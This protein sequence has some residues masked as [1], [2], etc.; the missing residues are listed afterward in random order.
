MVNGH[1]YLSLFFPTILSTL[2]CDFEIVVF[3]V[4][5]RGMRTMRTIVGIKPEPYI[6]LRSPSCFLTKLANKYPHTYY[7]YVQKLLCHTH[8]GY[9]QLP[10]THKALPGFSD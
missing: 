3:G 1:D 8:L 2:E 9:S 5:L 6:N 4:L 7:K 10:L